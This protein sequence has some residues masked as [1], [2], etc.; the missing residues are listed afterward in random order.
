MEPE[1][2]VEICTKVIEAAYIA[3]TPEDAEEMVRVM[4]GYAPQ[5]PPKKPGAQ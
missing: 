3:A 5:E 4:C 2:F 1:M